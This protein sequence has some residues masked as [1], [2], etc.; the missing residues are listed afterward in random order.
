MSE[1]IRKINEEE[2]DKVAGGSSVEDYIHFQSA[3]GHNVGDAVS[4][5]YKILPAYYQDMFGFEERQYDGV[6]SRITQNP[7]GSFILLIEHPAGTFPGGWITLEQLNSACVV[8][9]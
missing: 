5:L 8:I 2:L 7:D 1:D 9:Q 6:I 3:E 4:I